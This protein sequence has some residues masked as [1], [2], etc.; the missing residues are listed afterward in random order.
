MA[1]VINKRKGWSIE[2]KVKVLR[3]IK[4]VKISD[5]C[6]KFCLENSVIQ[7]IFKNG[8]TIKQF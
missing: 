2:G 5:V 6:Q 3:Q 1:T 8:T 7:T 4:N